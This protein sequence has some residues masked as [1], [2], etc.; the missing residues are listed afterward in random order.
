M[1]WFTLA[2]GVFSV[3]AGITHFLMPREQLH[4]ASGIQPGFFESLRISSAAFTI[5]YWAIIASTLAGAAVVIGIGS[6]LNMPQGIILTILSVG[7]VCGFVVTSVSFGL[8]L[9]RAIHIS[10]TWPNLSQ[11][12]KET[13]RTNGLP[14]LDPLGLFG[15]GLVGIWLVAFNMAAIT[16]QV[17]PT[18]HG[19]A[20]CVGGLLYLSVLA[21]MTFHIAFLVD[22]SAALGCVVIAPI[23]SIA[24]AVKLF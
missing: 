9:K 8:M 4:M 1:A 21:G 19:M 5:H 11:H 22:V 7:A 16:M 6:A 2:M 3:V 20:G 15:F 17:L 12:T 14:N 23:W 18:W 10:H 24:L 13:I